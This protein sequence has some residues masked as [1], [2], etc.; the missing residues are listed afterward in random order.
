MRRRKPE[1]APLLGVTRLRRHSSSS[2]ACKQKSQLTELASAR[3][4]TSRRR[5]VSRNINAVGQKVR[6]LNRH[7][8]YI[9][10]LLPA[11]VLMFAAGMRGGTE[12]SAPRIP[13][14]VPD[15]QAQVRPS[16]VSPAISLLSSM[17]LPASRS[18]TFLRAWG[19]GSTRRV[20]RNVMRNLRSEGQSDRQPPGCRRPIAAPQIR[21]LRSS[22]PTVQCARQGSYTLDLQHVDGGVIFTITGRN[23]AAGCNIQQDN[24]AEAAQ[25]GVDLSHTNS[26]IR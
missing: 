7:R 4:A 1:P 6:H 23:D 15:L 18:T 20:A 19:R 22:P 14:C 11:L 13:A 16:Q 12:N 24:F 17:R 25:L 3:L 5:T 8:S 26:S 10:L 21:Y 9:L 2:C